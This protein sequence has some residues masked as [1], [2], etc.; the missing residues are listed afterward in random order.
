MFVL[1]LSCID[2]DPQGP[3]APGSPAA[4]SL[5]HLDEVRRASADI[6]EPVVRIQALLVELR[7]GTRP[8]DEVLAELQVEL[9]RAQEADARMQEALDAAEGVLEAP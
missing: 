7:E 6:E 5:E 8:A 3:A 4:R 1:L 2:A 9:D